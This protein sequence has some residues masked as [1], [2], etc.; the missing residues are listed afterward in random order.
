MQ[1]PDPSTA[2]FRDASN[3]ITHDPHSK[4][5]STMMVPPCEDCPGYLQHLFTQRQS[6][7]EGGRGLCLCRITATTGR[8]STVPPWPKATPRYDNISHVAE[9]DKRSR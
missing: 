2:I 4:R 1:R 7:A 9:R 6:T 3:V 8:T 5:P